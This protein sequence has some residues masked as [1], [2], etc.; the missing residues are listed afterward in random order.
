MTENNSTGVEYQINFINNSSNAGNFMVF[1]EHPDMNMMDSYALAWFTKFVHPNTNGSFS[2]KTGFDFAWLEQKSL[3]AGITSVTSQCLPAN[4][5]ANNVTLL[6]Y[7]GGYNF[8]NQPDS[9]A[10]GSL[11]IK[12]DSTIGPDQVKIGF[13][14]SGAP[15]FMVGAQ[16]NLEVV[17]TPNPYYWIA[18]GEYEK[19]Q[20][21]NAKEIPN[22][23]RI[24]FPEGIT[25]MNVVLNPDNTWTAHPA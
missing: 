13:G 22:S 25:T 16:P 8:I 24:D 23:M 18:F 21:V 11:Y 2:W 20:V 10:A 19:G 5:E 6:T 3:A 12:T 9:G 1:Q 4:L 14:M 17:F 7:D 15:V